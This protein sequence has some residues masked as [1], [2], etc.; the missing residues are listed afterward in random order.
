MPGVTVLLVSL[1]EIEA[2]A[3]GHEHSK[4]EE[5]Q[6]SRHGRKTYLLSAAPRIKAD[7]RRMPCQILGR[8]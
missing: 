6:S 7:E 1:V 2:A 3:E 8:A 4:G 5:R